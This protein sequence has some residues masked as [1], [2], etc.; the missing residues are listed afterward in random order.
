MLKK[1]KLK[2]KPYIIMRMQAPVQKKVAGSSGN[3]WDIEDNVDSDF[4][5]NTI[6]KKVRITYITYHLVLNLLQARLDDALKE[7]VMKIMLKYLPGVCPLHPDLSC[8]HHRPSN[9]HFKLDRPQLLVWAQAIKLGSATYEKIPCYRLCS[10][11]RWPSNMRQ[12]ALLRM[13]IR[14]ALHPH[15]LPLTWHRLYLPCLSRTFH[16]T[17]RC[18]LCLRSWVLG[19]LACHILLAI[20]LPL[21][22]AWSPCQQSPRHLSHHPLPTARSRTFARSTT[23]VSRQQSS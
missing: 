9:S 1:I 13:P 11:H 7:I 3:A 8:F 2:K 17:L 18:H 12:K 6:A 22:R 20:P 23:W 19:C 16:H 15:H 21:V 10:R 5:D 4:E 14:P